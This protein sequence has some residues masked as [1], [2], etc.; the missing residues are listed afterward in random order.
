MILS[1]PPKFIQK[2]YPS[3]T[4]RIPTDKKNIY[5]TFD[6]GPTPE[7]TSQ[8]LDLLKEYN[9][10]GTFFCLGKNIREYQD[11]FQRI[12][13][14]GHKVGN[15]SNRHKNGWKNTTPDFLLDVEDFNKVYVSN[16]FRPPY[17]RMKNSQIKI[18]K[19]K[20]KIIM[21]SIL[22]MDYDQSVS[23]KSCAKIATSNWEKGS[24]LVFH[25]S[26]KAANNMI[27][28]LEQVLLK[29]KKEGWNC[30]MIN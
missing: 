13:K 12:L 6:D 2:V 24:I 22:T 23:S 28:A 14:E 4:W 5:L 25:D 27:F 11:I 1:Y 19:K 16:L 7:I 17:G 8:V 26:V 18:L 21:W 29:A 9:A 30:P 20:Y 15:H 10:K 3:L